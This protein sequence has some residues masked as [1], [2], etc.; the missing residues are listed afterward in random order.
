MKDVVMFS[1]TTS[2][3]NSALYFHE[4]ITSVDVFR[5][6]MLT[7]ANVLQQ[8][9]QQQQQEQQ[10]EQQQQPLEYTPSSRSKNSDSL[11]WCVY[12]IH[13]Q[14][15]SVV[16][17][18]KALEM[19]EKMAAVKWLTENKLPRQTLSANSL[20]KHTAELMSS[21][22]TTWGALYLLCHYYKINVRIVGK[23][24]FMD[25]VGSD[26]EDAPLYRIEREDA[27]QRFHV[28]GIVT[29]EAAD[30]SNKIAQD[31]R[32]AKPLRGIGNYK[33]DELKSLAAR[34]GLTIDAKKK[35]DW[36]DAVY[37]AL[38]W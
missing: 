30:D 20:Q 5:P 32:E 23:H 15:N 3:L 37:K 6:W 25:V 31:F 2:F 28:R 1:H 34:L 21:P 36:Y 29:P 24:M 9:Q 38:T 35:Q 17:E 26:G 14:S 10:E 7:A 8:E 4:P 18:S 19:Q 12:A 16:E 27:A 13:H 33:V 11:F 22:A